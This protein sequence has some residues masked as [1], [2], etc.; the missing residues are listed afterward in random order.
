[1]SLIA[2]HDIQA[3]YGTRRALDGVSFQAGDGE[4]V[5]LV[6]PNGAGKTTLLRVLAGLMKPASGQVLFD[7]Q[8]FGDVGRRQLAQRLAYLPQ[9]APVH[10]PLKV[11]KLVAL[12]RLPHLDPWSNPGPVDEIAITRAMNPEEA[13]SG[14][15]PVCST[16]GANSARA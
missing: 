4:L 1:M 13:V 10:W 6:G 12:G 9:G 14:P 3:R 8:P 16:H 11:G 5:G 7:G 2:A 15:S